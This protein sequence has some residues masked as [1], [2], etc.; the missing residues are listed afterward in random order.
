[1]RPFTGGDLHVAMKST[2]IDVT[3]KLVSG[4]ALQSMNPQSCFPPFS[5]ELGGPNAGLD[6]EAEHEHM[7]E[8]GVYKRGPKT[9]SHRPKVQT[10]TFA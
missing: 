7:T 10:P 5:I 8:V 6:C 3:I 9:Q 4:M 1:M 2:A